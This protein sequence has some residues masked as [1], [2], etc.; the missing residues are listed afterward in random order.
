MAADSWRGHD[1]G[2]LVV[3]LFVSA[4]V[5]MGLVVYLGSRLAPDALRRYDAVRGTRD[6]ALLSVAV[7]VA[8]YLWGLL[9]LVFVDEQLQGQECEVRRPEGADLVGRRGDFV[10]L[11]LVCEV[12][13][14]ADYGVLV[15]GYVNPV[16]AVLLPLACFGAVASGVLSR[17]RRVPVRG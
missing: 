4:A 9:H 16:L 7:S 14:G 2:L 6:V 10:P 5:L 17:L 12:A 1:P 11:R 15:P 8:F 3:G 13:G